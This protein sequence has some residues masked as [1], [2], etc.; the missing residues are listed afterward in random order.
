MGMRWGE[1][2]IASMYGSFT[3]FYLHLVDSCG[4]CR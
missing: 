3:M 2:P 4:K 1:M